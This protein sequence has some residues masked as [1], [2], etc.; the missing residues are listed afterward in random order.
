MKKDI[1]KKIGLLLNIVLALASYG[2]IIIHIYIQHNNKLHNWSSYISCAMAVL[3]FAIFFVF[4]DKK[5]RIFSGILMAGVIS[6]TLGDLILGKN[7]I[8]GAG[9]FGFGHVLYCASF[10]ILKFSFKD[11]C[12]DIIFFLSFAGVGLMIV[13]VPYVDYGKNLALL[14]VYVFVLSL[15]LGKA[16]SN[17][18]FSKEKRILNI[19]MAIGAFLFYFSDAML[20]LYWFKDASLICDRLCLM[21][22]IPAQIV[23]ACGALITIFTKKDENKKVEQIIEEKKEPKN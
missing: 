16:V 21:T 9:L 5:E 20:L 11:I 10:C 15:M 13:F 8:L 1:I 22:Y 3:N 14:F 2:L 7:M 18:I 12:K 17:A 23:L 19:S 4:M 6:A